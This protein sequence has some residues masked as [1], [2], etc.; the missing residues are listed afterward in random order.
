MNIK[1]ESL[2]VCIMLSVSV[3]GMI[4]MTKGTGISPAIKPAIKPASSGILIYGT[5]N[6]PVDWDPLF[7]W[8]TASQDVLCQICE[9]LFEYNYSNVN[10]PLIPMLA[11]SYSWS[12]SKTLTVNLHTGITFQD[13]TPFNATAAKWNFDRM[14]WTFNYTSGLSA[15]F[16][17]GYPTSFG[18]DTPMSLYQCP[19]GTQLFN[20]VVVLNSSAIQFTLNEPYSAFT[21]LLAFEGSFMLSPASTPGKAEIDPT[22]SNYRPVGTGPFMF[23][24]Y[25][26]SDHVLL[27]A[28]P[29]YW[30]GA[31]ALAGV[32]YNIINDAN[33]RNTAMINQEINILPDPL[34]NL[35]TGGSFNVAGET[36]HNGPDDLFIQYIGMN[37]QI[38][39]QSCRKAMTYAFD[40]NYYLTQVLQGLSSRLHG[41][42][43]NGM[44]FYNGSIPY[45]VNQNLTAARKALIAMATTAGLSWA[46]A[47]STNLNVNSWWTNMAATNPIATYNYTYNAGNLVRQQIGVLL[48]NCSALVGIKV[49]ALTAADWGAFIGDLGNWNHQKYYPLFALGWAP[50]FNDPDDYVH[51]LLMPG[52]TSDMA[53]VND[54]QINASIDASLSATTIAGRQAAYNDLMNY[55]Q[56]GLYPWI[57]LQQGHL[58]QVWTDNVLGY[59]MNI[60]D[61][62]YFY[63]VSLNVSTTPGGPTGTSGVPGYDVAILSLSIITT[64]IV[65]IVIV[66]KKTL[67]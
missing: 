34:P 23:G 31:P 66:R 30:R 15:P 28:N 7:A 18:A 63:G 37:N 22:S 27:N 32:Y 59:T 58:R 8:D 26:V 14:L 24:T 38:I 55:T 64:A 39:N 13:G 1:K 42:I 19:N 46:S 57:F 9:G 35:I 44:A 62:C 48:T 3:F 29:N 6:G 56:N 12:N 54:A 40:Y 36:V 10:A 17:T 67:A 65:A 2:I 5:S 45:V 51:P 11:S 50:D 41:P 61:Q 21:S 25:V 47:A 20:P 60:M 16:N 49:T 43:P 52:S 33:A 4:G 53:H